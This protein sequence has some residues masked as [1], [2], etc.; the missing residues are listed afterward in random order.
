VPA[1]GHGE[2]DIAATAIDAA[3]DP[4]ECVRENLGAGSNVGDASGEL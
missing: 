3:V 2:D 4:R 1:N